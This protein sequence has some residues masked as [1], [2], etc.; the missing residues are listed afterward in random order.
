[1]NGGKYFTGKSDGL[2]AGRDNADIHE[3]KSNLSEAL[4]NLM[5]EEKRE[6]ICLIEAG[7]AVNSIAINQFPNKK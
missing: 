2:K 5:C 6:K 7:N 1:M 4:Q 3:G